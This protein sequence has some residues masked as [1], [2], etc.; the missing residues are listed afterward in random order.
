MTQEAD[1]TKAI[2]KDLRAMGV[3]AFKYWGGL[4]GTKGVSDILRVLPWAGFLQSVAPWGALPS[5]RGISKRS[6]PS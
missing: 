1:I 5:W 3:F 4:M 2:L 6:G